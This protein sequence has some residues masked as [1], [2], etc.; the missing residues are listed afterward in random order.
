VFNEDDSGALSFCAAEPPTEA[1]LAK[2]VETIRTR[3]LRRLAR[4]G[5]IDGDPI[6]DEAPALASCYAGSIAG[7]QSLGSRPGAKLQRIGADPDAQWVHAGGPQQ[8]QADGF[9]LH[10]ARTVPAQRQDQRARLEELLRYCARPP[11]SDERLRIAAD[12]SI[13]L[14]LKTPWKDGSTH[15]VYEPLDFIAKLA[16]LPL[17]RARIRISSCITVCSRLTLRGDRA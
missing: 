14:R 10:A 13:L 16:A 7:R 12:G 15:V 11:I 5:D 6:D 9:D 2:L 4:R 8:A 1:E 17:C 3:V